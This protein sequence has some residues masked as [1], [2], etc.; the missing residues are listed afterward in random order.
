MSHKVRVGR[1]RVWM[2]KVWSEYDTTQSTLIAEQVLE[3]E[4]GNPN[5]IANPDFWQPHPNHLLI[6]HFFNIMQFMCMES[7]LFGTLHKKEKRMAKKCNYRGYNEALAWNLTQRTIIL[8]LF[9]CI[10][11]LAELVYFST[12]AFTFTLCC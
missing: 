10:H 1:C 11:K 6:V 7:G 2:L 12:V 8:D 5:M 4:F 9:F 3:K